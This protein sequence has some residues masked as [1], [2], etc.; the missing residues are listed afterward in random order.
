MK[1]RNWRRRRG[2]FLTEPWWAMYGL[3]GPVDVGVGKRRQSTGTSNGATIRL[4]VVDWCL[5]RTDGFCQ[6]L[7]VREP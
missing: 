5:G 2:L 6:S 7:A 4:R 3:R 1:R